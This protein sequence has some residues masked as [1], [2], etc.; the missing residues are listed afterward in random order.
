MLLGKSQSQRLKGLRV[1]NGQH[2]AAEA[3]DQDAGWVQTPLGE[4]QSYF[5]WKEAQ[6]G[7]RKG[8]EALPNQRRRLWTTADK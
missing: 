7:D 8:R 5:T 4:W 2:G 6:R 1:C 3:L